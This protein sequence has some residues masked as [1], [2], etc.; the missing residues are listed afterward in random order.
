MAIKK[1][2]PAKLPAAVAMARRATD[3]LTPEQRTQRARNAVNA[4]WRRAKLPNGAPPGTWY[5]LVLIPEDPNPPKPD[6]KDFVGGVSAGMKLLNKA[7][8]NPEVV[9][10]SRNRAEVVTHSQKK[11]WRDRWTE[12][13]E[14]NHNQG[15]RS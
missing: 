14:T 15:G 8:A 7:L 1:R 10:W 12:I 11:E 9:F 3:S 5:G 2:A 4:R 6:D 13:I